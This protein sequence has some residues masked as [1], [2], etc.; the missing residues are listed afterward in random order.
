[1]K[2]PCIECLHYRDHG[3]PRH[4]YGTSATIKRP[5][6]F[7]VHPEFRK[8]TKKHPITGV[9]AGGDIIYH[10]CENMRVRFTEASLDVGLDCPKFESDN[11]G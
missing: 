1:M 6:H 8:P 5:G 3:H 10:E 7:C 11:P 9:V 4:I 2:T